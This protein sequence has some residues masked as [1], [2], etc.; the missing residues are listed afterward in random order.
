MSLIERNFY[1]KYISTRWYRSPEIL[2]KFDKY[3]EKV[4]IF[5]LGCLICELILNKPIF[6]GENEID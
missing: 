5:A 1:T 3:D 4:D 6:M 2:L